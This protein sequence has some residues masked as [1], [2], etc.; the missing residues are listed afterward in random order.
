MLHDGDSLKEITDGWVRFERQ[1]G[2]LESLQS[3]MDAYVEVGVGVVFV[4]VD[5]RSRKDREI[6]LCRNV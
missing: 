3:A 5:F 6:L 1:C 2:T 4:S